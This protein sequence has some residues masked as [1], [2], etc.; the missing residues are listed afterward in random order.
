VEAAKALGL[1]LIN[2]MLKH[3]FPNI[4]GPILVYV[5]LDLGSVILAEAGLSYLGVGAQPP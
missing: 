4:M 5:T 1:S 3:I 2:I